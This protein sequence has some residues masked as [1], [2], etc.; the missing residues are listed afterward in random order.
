MVAFRLEFWGDEQV[1]RTLERWSDNA[2]DLTP[3]WDELRDRFVRL[4]ERQFSSQGRYGSGGWSPLSP[5][6]ASWKAR[7]YP[8]RPI[9][10][11]E[12]D[13]RR[14]LTE[15]AVYLATPRSMVVGSDV[16][17]GL[18]HQ[19]G[20]GVPRRRPVELPESERREWVQVLQR[21]IV[22]GRV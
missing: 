13:L 22:T 14:S 16:E 4:E 1:S 20:D 11:R 15:P 9:L 5:G 21:F 19:R 8:G 7:H 17:H 10:E 3:A 18:Y 2:E 12:G 6:Y